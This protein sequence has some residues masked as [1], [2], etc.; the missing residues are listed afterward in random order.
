MSSIDSHRTSYGTL[1]DGGQQTARSTS[2]DL[3]GNEHFERETRKAVRKI[4]MMILPVMTAFYLLS[5]LDRANIGNARVAGLQRDLGMSDHQY[6]V[7]VTVLFIPYILSEIPAN[8]L[9]RKIGPSILLPTLLTVW[10]IIVTLQGWVST[11]AELIVLRA[12]LGAVEGPMAPGIVLYLSGFYTRKELS[13]RVAIFFSAAS[14]AGA[15]SGLLAAAIVLMDGLRGKAGW[16]W[17]FILEGTFTIVVGLL[18][19]FL[20]PPSPEKARFLSTKQKELILYRLNKDRPATSPIYSRF[21]IREVV[22]SITSPHVLLVA[23]I[24]Y[25]QGTNASG[26]AL[27]M[28]SIINQLGFGANESQLL[29]V[30]PYA[31]G[32]IVTLL[33]AFFSDRFNTRAIPIAMIYSLA[34]AGFAMYLGADDRYVRYGSLFLSVSGVYASTP[35]IYAWISNNSEPH[36]R[37]ATSIALGVIATNSGGITSTW[38]YPSKDAPRFK[39]AII[40]NL[41]FAILVMVVSAINSLILSRANRLKREKRFKILAP[42]LERGV[43]ESGGGMK[44][45]TELGDRHPDYVYTI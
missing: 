27:F 29:S 26:I 32:I 24:F 30:G 7:A 36:Y 25:L 38:L 33:S 43:G 10:G 28:P 34:V 5:F 42:Y 22:R 45:W 21:S 20:V 11:Y 40:I 37:R 12:L 13:L 17:I 4:D 2:V 39:K 14:L 23:T 8:L 15:F 41:V 9:L 44:A 31:G 3:G 1:E 35:I 6:S 18:G 16:A 19:F